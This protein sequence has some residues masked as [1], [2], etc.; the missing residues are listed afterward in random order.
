MT[1]CRVAIFTIF[2]LLICKYEGIFFKVLKFLLY[3]SFNSLVSFISRFFEAVLDGIYR[4]YL[5]C[6]V[7]HL[8]AGRLLILCINLYCANF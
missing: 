4:Q 8:Y 1:L 7:C 6:Y 3:K 2:I 5:S